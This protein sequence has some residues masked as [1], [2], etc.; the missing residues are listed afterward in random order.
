M[1][2][3]IQPGPDRFP[4]YPRESVVQ[5]LHNPGLIGSYAI[6]P[7]TGQLKD[8]YAVVVVNDTDVEQALDDC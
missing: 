6:V 8:D 7:S 5:P 4:L 2:K 1:G 3:P